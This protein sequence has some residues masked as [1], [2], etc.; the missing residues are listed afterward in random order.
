MFNVK[1]EGT[2]YVKINVKPTLQGID[3]MMK[4]LNYLIRIVNVFFSEKFSQL[5]T[6]LTGKNC[7][8]QF[9]TRMADSLLLI[10]FISSIH[11]IISY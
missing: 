9:N 1:M 8:I 7:F 11:S 10:F 4:E 3:V 5:L 6:I 2:Y